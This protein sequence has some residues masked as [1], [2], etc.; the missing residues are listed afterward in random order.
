MSEMGLEASINNETRLVK[1]ESSSTLISAIAAPVV[2]V[3]SLG[4]ALWL[5]LAGH[6]PAALA[7]SVPLV[8]LAVT[9]VVVTINARRK[10]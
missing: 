5:G 1:A 6:T 9:Q 4:V 8:G 2:S 3:M 10:E 7:T